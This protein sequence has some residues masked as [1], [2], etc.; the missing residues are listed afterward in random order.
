MNRDT[1]F[2]L[3]ELMSVVAIIGVMSA[4]AGPFYNVYRQKAYNAEASMMAKSLLNGQ[5]SY[6]LEYNA[7]IG[8]PFIFL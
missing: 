4:T 3:V 6:F 8:C 7:E 2:T 1:G 5:I